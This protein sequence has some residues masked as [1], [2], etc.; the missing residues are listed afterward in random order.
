MATLTFHQHKAMLEALAAGTATPEQQ[1][2][3]F[4]YLLAI[5]RQHAAELREADRDARDAYLEGR[6]DAG[7]ESRGEPFGTF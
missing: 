5:K 3:A 2:Q 4:E 1:R 7:R 6:G